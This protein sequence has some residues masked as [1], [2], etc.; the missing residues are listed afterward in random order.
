MTEKIATITAQPGMRPGTV[1]HLITYTEDGQDVGRSY[2]RPEDLDEWKADLT[3]Q[4][5]TVQDAH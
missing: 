3:V 2:A 4:G 1:I 5:W